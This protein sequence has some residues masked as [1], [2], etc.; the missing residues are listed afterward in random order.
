MFCSMTKL[1]PAFS[2]GAWILSRIG[3]ARIV[4]TI[5]MEIHPISSVIVDIGLPLAYFQR[6][7]G[8]FTEISI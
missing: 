1:D 8:V 4:K 6:I 7:P 3:A 2:E 5:S